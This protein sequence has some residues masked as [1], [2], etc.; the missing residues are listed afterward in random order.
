MIEEEIPGKD[1]RWSSFKDKRAEDMYR[2]IDRFAFPFIK[3]MGDNSAFSK[4]MENATFS[5]PAGK[6]S[7]LEKAV[8]ESKSSWRILTSISE[9]LGDL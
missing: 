4:A 5:F 9:I 2:I 1:I 8:T 3:T 7:L 6:P